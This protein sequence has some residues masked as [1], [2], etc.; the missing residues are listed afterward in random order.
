MR[1]QYG[2]EAQNSSTKSANACPALK[3][4]V[5][6]QAS[7]FPLRRI[8]HRPRKLF[9]QFGGGGIFP[10]LSFVFP[11]SILYAPAALLRLEGKQTNLYFLGLDYLQEVKSNL[12]LAN[13]S[14][15]IKKR[16]HG[17]IRTCAA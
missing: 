6:K 9:G 2:V 14:N 11:A 13:A 4:R 16:Q 17:T 7:Q 5:A 8:E 3:A 10:I 1:L 15:T 12:A